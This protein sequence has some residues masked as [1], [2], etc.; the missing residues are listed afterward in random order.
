MLGLLFA[1]HSQAQVMTTSSYR[2]TSIPFIEI[3][4]SLYNYNYPINS[5]VLALLT[6]TP[7]QDGSY[8]AA[9]YGHRYLSSTT[10]KTD[11]HGGFDYWPDHNYQGITYDDNNKAPII[12]MCDGIITQVLN[13][14]DAA[15]EQ[16]AT[17]RSVQVE[18]NG[19]T[20]S[21]GSNFKINYRHLSSL[22][23]H[24]IT[25]ETAPANS[26]TINKGDVIGSIGASGFTSNV[27]L[28]MSAQLTHP[29]N[30]NY[31]VHTARLFDPTV[32][33]QI[34]TTLNQANISL[35]HRWG[36]K[37]LFRVTWPYNQSINQFEFSNSNY[38][39]I[40]NKEDAYDTGSSIRDNHD[41]L[42]QIEVYAYQF[43]GKLDAASRYNNEKVNMPAIYPA[44]PQRDSD[45]ATYVYPHYPITEN[46]ISY[47]YDF[48][49]D[50][51][52]NNALN[53]D[54]EVK[55][56]DVWGY[57]V[58]GRMSTASIE[59]QTALKV[60][61]FPNPVT[62]KLN[63]QFNTVNE[64]SLIQIYDFKGVLISSFETINK[65]EIINTNSYSQG[66]YFVRVWNDSGSNNL[67]FIKK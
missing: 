21:Y 19:T 25:A 38:Q 45:I 46:S 47:V 30:G 14:T 13:G 40:F 28:H 23:T 64:S 10:N 11:N 53:D 8:L 34:L 17:G 12:C 66:I 51:L 26:I 44:S 15:M 42:P 59:D 60:H 56:S 35:L 6:Y 18:C 63:V 55:L 52:P 31:F 39:V 43:N 37:A 48:V 61:L 27:H 65:N 36:N 3:N 62:D 32:H 49:I 7:P 9:S 4:P 50:N 24:A 54:F 20:Q 58:E 5:D 29:T 2:D 33:P 41:C 67:K 16:T 1:F 22:G 57:T